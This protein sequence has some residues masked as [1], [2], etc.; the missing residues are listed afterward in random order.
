VLAADTG[1]PLPYARLSVVPCEPLGDLFGLRHHV[2]ARADAEGRFRVQPLPGG[3]FQVFACAPEDEPYLTLVQKVAWPAGTVRQELTLALPPGIALRGQVV[4]AETGQPVAGALV[5]CLTHHFTTPDEPADESQPRRWGEGRAC[6]GRDGR[7][8]VPVAAGRSRLRVYAPRGGYLMRPLETLPENERELYAYAYAHA[9]VPLELPANCREHEVRV[10]LQRCGRLHG[11]V[12]DA[13]GR[14]VRA[15]VVITAGVF[16]HDLWT[17]AR[18]FAVRDGGFTLTNIH[19]RQHYPFVVLDRAHEQGA[20]AVMTGQPT[21]ETPTLRL[22][23]CG[24]AEGQLLDSRQRPLR[25]YPLVLAALLTASPPGQP[26]EGTEANWYLTLGGQ[27]RLRTDDA[28]RFTLLA[29]VPGVSY[30]LYAGTGASRRLTREFRVTAGQVL[31][32]DGV[33][34]PR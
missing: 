33:V 23:P 12:L 32:L 24:R 11:Q 7:F 3:A 28:G 4:D 29:L 18:R 13:D 14:P 15:G 22:Q 27:E 17:G 9:V 10:D 34:T 8:L 26:Q 16:A 1:R 2:D 25:D 20:F 6:S 30:R 19:P 21:G 5:E 31:Q